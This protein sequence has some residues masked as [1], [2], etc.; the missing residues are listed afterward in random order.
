MYSWIKYGCRYDTQ[1]ILGNIT[2]I[3]VPYSYISCLRLFDNVCEIPKLIANC[4]IRTEDHI[5]TPKHYI[6]ESKRKKTIRKYF[7]FN[8]F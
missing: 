4:I 1:G 5:F 3:F 6:Y 8:L 7:I 2:I